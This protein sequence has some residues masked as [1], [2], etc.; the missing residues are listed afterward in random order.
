MPT[1][2]IYWSPGRSP[3]QKKAIVENMT[4]LLVEHGDAKREDVLIIFQNI[5]DGDAGRGGK[6]LSSPQ[7]ANKHNADRETNA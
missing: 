1:V 3:E 4:D 2:L 7:L 6:M 5:E